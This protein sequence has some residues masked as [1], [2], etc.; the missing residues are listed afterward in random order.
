[1]CVGL[2]SLV[3]KTALLGKQDCV[4]NVDIDRS[5][6]VSAALIRFNRER[7]LLPTNRATVGMAQM[8]AKCAYREH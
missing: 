2:T 4:V 1:M 5:R 8:L 6:L 3:G 7:L